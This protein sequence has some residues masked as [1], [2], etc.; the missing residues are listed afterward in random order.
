MESLDSLNNEYSSARAAFP[1]QEINPLSPP[2]EVFKGIDFRLT[3][4]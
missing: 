2:T 3:E 1:K 4:A